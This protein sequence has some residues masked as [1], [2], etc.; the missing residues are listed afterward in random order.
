MTALPMDS[1]MLS[2][3][4]AINIQKIHEKGEWLLPFPF[5]ML[6]CNDYHLSTGSSAPLS[7]EDRSE[8]VGLGASSTGGAGAGVAG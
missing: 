2:K 4:C 7:P 3:K 6:D 5:Y 8:A 1:S